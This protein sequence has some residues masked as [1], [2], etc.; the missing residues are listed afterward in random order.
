MYIKETKCFGKFEGVFSLQILQFLLNKIS[1][2]FQYKIILNFK[3]SGHFPQKVEKET[4]TLRL[5]YEQ[6]YV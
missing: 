6:W 5:K 3:I 1:Q 2:R 4:K